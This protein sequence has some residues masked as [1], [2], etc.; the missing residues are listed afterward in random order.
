M[1]SLPRSKPSRLL[2]ALVAA[3]QRPD[4]AA[5]AAALYEALHK[6]LNGIGRLAVVEVPDRAQFVG[7]VGPVD[8]QA[9]YNDWERAFADPGPSR[10][11]EAKWRRAHAVSRDRCRELRRA[12]P[13]TRLHKMGRRQTRS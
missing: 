13:S 11:D 7:V 3:L 6:A 5:L 9:L 2:T 1:P 12:C 8:E 10:A 4:S